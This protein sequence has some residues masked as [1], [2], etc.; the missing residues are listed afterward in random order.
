MSCY[1]DASS[2][3]ELLGCAVATEDNLG[4]GRVLAPLAHSTL[5][6]LPV[7]GILHEAR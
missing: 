2:D 6:L 7:A 4:L 3:S 1:S 5:I